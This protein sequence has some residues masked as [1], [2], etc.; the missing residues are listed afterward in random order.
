MRRCRRRSRRPDGAPRDVRAAL[1]HLG[2]A[3]G[4]DPTR[5]AVIG[6]SIGANLAVASAIHGE[7]TTYVAISARRPPVESL[8]A[9]PADGMTSVLYLAAELDGGDQATDSTTMFDATAEPRGLE[10]FPGIADHGIDLLDGPPAARARVLA[11]LD[12]TL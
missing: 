8:A 9:A 2:G 6:T 4:A 3:G 7:A 11:W 1:A 12:E 10:I 5:L